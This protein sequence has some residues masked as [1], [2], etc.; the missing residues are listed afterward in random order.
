MLCFLLE[1]RMG[2]VVV[3]LGGI[4]K[5]SDKCLLV[6]THTSMV[7]ILW[8]KVQGV[9]VETLPAPKEKEEGVRSDWLCWFCQLKPWAVQ[10]AEL[11]I[12]WGS[13]GDC[14]GFET[15]W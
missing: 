14:C 5:S 4:L 6:L 7:S 12:D 8:K 3:R 11:H 15:S 10:K 1:E 9:F 2:D 13:A